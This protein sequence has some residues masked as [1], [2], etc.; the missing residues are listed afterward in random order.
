MDINSGLGSSTIFAA[1]PVRS[2]I[3]DTISPQ[4]AMSPKT[5]VTSHNIGPGGYTGAPEVWTSAD[6]NMYFRSPYVFQDLL[7]H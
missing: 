1:G 2:S 5:I 7:S 4:T 3:D 6:L